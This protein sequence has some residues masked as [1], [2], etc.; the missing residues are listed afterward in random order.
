MDLHH[1]VDGRV[2]APV[3]VLGGSLGSTLDMWA[4]QVDALTGSLRVVRY[5]HRG[6]GGTP[7][8]PGPYA[9][10]DLGGDVLGLLDRLGIERAH[11]GGLSL[12]GMVAMWL[13][14]HAPERVDR[15]ALL[16]TSARLGPASAWEERAAT[17]RANGTGA[18]APTI[19]G[20]WFTAR[21]AHRHPEM[22]EGFEA[23]IGSVTDEGYAACCDAIRTMDL[24]DELPSVRA[25]TLV[26]AGAEDP[27]TPP[28]HARA[29]GD[30][31][32]GARVEIV[33][34]AAHLASWE[35]AETVNALLLD[36]LLGATDG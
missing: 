26:I 2:D 22:V 36:H 8:V 11:M 28:E 19:V 6:H 5:D 18:I 4:P 15:L 3:L 24:L 16:C 20:R 34:G 17:V 32:A 12:G 23:M 30:R 25:P 21:F 7:A 10:A 29:I 1:V 13:A 35:Q 14:V 9:L 31:V 27:A 33:T